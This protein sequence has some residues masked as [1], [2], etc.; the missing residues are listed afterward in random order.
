MSGQSRGPGVL[1]LVVTF[2]VAATLIPWAAYA[3]ELTC[4]VHEAYACRPGAGCIKHVPRTTS[5]VD[6]DR[7]K[8]TRCYQKGC[9][10]YDMKLVRSGEYALIEVS[11]RGM[12]AKINTAGSFMEVVTLTDQ[13]LISYG[14]CK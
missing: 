11:G 10:E 12:L 2:F 14:T 1:R 3:K 4:E 9:D 7:K 6:S 13:A 8:Y 5:R